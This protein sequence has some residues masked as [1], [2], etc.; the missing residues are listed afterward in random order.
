[1]HFCFEAPADQVTTRAS[2]EKD[3]FQQ[4]VVVPKK[5]D[6]VDIGAELTEEIDKSKY[7]YKGE[8]L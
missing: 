3:L 5:L 4:V 2:E 1:M 6:D 7:M 8:M